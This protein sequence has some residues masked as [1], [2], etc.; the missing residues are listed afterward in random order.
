[1]IGAIA[2]DIIGSRF[3]FHNRKSRHFTLFAPGCAPTDDSYMTLAIGLALLDGGDLASAAVRRMQQLGRRF[4]A[5]GYGARF[6]AWLES[7]APQPYQSF[8]NGAAMRISAVGD[9]A[10][11]VQTAIAWA[12]AV[13]AVTHDHPDAL[14]AAEAVAAAMVL[15]RQGARPDA[16]R[17]TVTARWGYRFDFTLD[18]IRPHYAFDVSCSGSVP[19]AFEAF[20]ESTGYEDAI[21]NAVS[22]GGDSDTIAAIAGALA[23][24]RH[25]VP[26]EIRTRAL[27]YLPEDLQQ[28]VRRIDDRQEEDA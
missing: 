10:P 15:L 6:A 12:R 16:V 9:L 4:P 3:E 23:Q 5:A 21:R 22:I 2:G 28:V 18:Q 1:M 20:F 27:S 24:S 7:D 13:T 14:R 11:D 17:E 26:V 25:G 8:G 19:Q